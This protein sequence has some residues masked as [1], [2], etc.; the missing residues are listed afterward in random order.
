M[1]GV[2]CILIAG[3]GLFSADRPAAFDVDGI[4]G[5][6]LQLDCQQ[7][8]SEDVQRL[9]LDHELRFMV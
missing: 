7:V 2:G 1:P 5:G 8:F 3:Q 4:A 6:R 9:V